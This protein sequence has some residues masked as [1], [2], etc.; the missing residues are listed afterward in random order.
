MAPIHVPVSAAI[1]P[2]LVRT[3]QPVHCHSHMHKK[4]KI[5]QLVYLGGGGGGGGGIIYCTVVSC[6]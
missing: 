2:R 6:S 1:T 4:C 5:L 3:I